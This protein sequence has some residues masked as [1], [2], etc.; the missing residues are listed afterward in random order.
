MP[1]VQE[2]SSGSSNPLQDQ[3]SSGT[4]ETADLQG[5]TSI[6][7]SPGDFEEARLHSVQA[8]FAD[9]YEVLAAI[10]HGGMGP[11]IR[12]SRSTRNAWSS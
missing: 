4:D 3:S 6:V 2:S 8:E 5:D 7:S 1:D 10:G 12:P 9:R 11:S